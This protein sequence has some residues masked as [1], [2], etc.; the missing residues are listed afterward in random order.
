MDWL[1]RE[2]DGERLADI[3]EERALPAPVVR[4]RVS[5]L[6]RAI[7][8]RYAGLFAIGLLLLIAGRFS[9]RTTDAPEVAPTITKE[10]VASATPVADRDLVDE[11]QGSWAVEAITPKRPLTSAEQRFVDRQLMAL[12]LRVD[13]RD[14]TTSLGTSLRVLKVVPVES[15]PHTAR[16]V[17]ERGQQRQEVLVSLR[18]DSRGARLEVVLEGTKYAGWVVLRRP[19]S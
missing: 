19:S 5:R 2:H 15:K 17:I 9:S 11:L 7:R 10:P 6:R 4:Q 18:K 1:V 12:Q 8:S 14:V 3:A 16:V 13:G